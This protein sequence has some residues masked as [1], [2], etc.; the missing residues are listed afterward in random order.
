MFLFYLFISLFVFFCYFSTFSHTHTIVLCALFAYVTFFSYPIFKIHT[1]IH[2]VPLSLSTTN[3]SISEKCHLRNKKCAEWS[4]WLKF[5]NS[6]TRE[7]TEEQSSPAK[8]TL[9]TIYL[10]YTTKESLIAMLKVKKTKPIKINNIQS[11]KKQKNEIKIK[12]TIL[13]ICTNYAH[14]IK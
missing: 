2:M 9:V 10:N 7:N 3:V 11:T 6:N 13:W 14:F 12:L 4:K 8:S 5:A 1:Y